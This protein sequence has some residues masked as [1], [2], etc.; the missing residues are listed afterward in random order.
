MLAAAG[1]PHVMKGTVTQKKAL[2]SRRQLWVGEGCLAYEGPVRSENIPISTDAYRE[3][4]PRELRLDI[5][6][7]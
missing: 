6:S 7:T 5:L 4:A 2:A 3:G 1:M